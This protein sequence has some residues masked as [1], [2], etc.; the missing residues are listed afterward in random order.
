MAGE[1]YT[2]F[3]FLGGSGFAYGRGGPVYYILQ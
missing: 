3:A 2:T 1:I